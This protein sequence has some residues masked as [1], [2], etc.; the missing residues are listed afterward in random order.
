VA[1]V[2]RD[3]PNRNGGQGASLSAVPPS[4]ALYIHALLQLFLET[5]RARVTLSLAHH[6]EALYRNPKPKT[7]PP[8]DSL[9]TASDLLSD[10]QVET[11]SSM[12]RVEKTKFIPEQMRLLLE[13]ARLKDGESP[14]AGKSDKGALSG[15]ETEWVKLRVQSRKVNERF[16]KEPGNEVRPSEVM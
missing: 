5:P 3:A 13:V 8:R 9:I 15:G 7:A 4:R 16:L 12:E 6:H 1:R 10:L 14:N 11:Y 2:G